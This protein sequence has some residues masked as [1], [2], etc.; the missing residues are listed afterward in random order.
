MS[1]SRPNSNENKSSDI[2]VVRQP[3]SN[4][5]NS[6]NLHTKFQIQCKLQKEARKKKCNSS[7]HLI[8]DVSDQQ[9]LRSN[10][11]KWETNFDT[12]LSAY[13]EYQNKETGETLNL[14]FTELMKGPIDDFIY[15]ID[16]LKENNTQK[17]IGIN[18]ATRLQG[19]YLNR[20]GIAYMYRDTIEAI[21]WFKE[22]VLAGNLLT[23]NNLYAT[24]GLYLNHT[25]NPSHTLVDETCEFIL[26]PHFRS[27]AEALKS[28]ER[29]NILLTLI[30]L[31]LQLKNEQRAEQFALQ[32]EEF[33]DIEHY[34]LLIEHLNTEKKQS[35]HWHMKLFE[36]AR[37]KWSDKTL[38][39]DEAKE[40]N[41]SFFQYLQSLAEQ[42]KMLEYIVAVEKNKLLLNAT[43]LL[44]AG[45]CFVSYFPFDQTNQKQRVLAWFLPAAM[46]NNNRAISIFLNISSKWMTT[47]EAKA[48]GYDIIIEKALA[49]NK[50]DAELYFVLGLVY[51]TG[52]LIQQSDSKAFEYYKKSADLGNV[53]AM[54]NI[55]TMHTDGQ[56]VEANL[57]LATQWYVKSI[58][59]GSY[60]AIR[61]L[62]SAY[63]PFFVRSALPDKMLEMLI[64]LIDESENNLKKAKIRKDAQDLFLARHNI[65]R[66]AI[67]ISTYSPNPDK[68]KIQA[69]IIQALETAIKLG[70]EDAIINASF[71]LASFYLHRINTS[72]NLLKAEALLL[73]A[74][75]LSTKKKFNTYYNGMICALLMHIYKFQEVHENDSA[76][77]NEL[78]LQALYYHFLA[79][80]DDTDQAVDH[81]FLKVYRELVNKLSGDSQNE[82]TTPILFNQHDNDLDH[83][84]EQLS[85]YNHFNK[86]LVELK[87]HD[88]TPCEIIENLTRDI[89]RLYQSM[90]KN[91]HFI[92]LAIRVAQEVS[93]YA[94]MPT[95]Q[96]NEL[97]NIIYNVSQWRLSAALDKLAGFVIYMKPEAYPIKQLIAALYTVATAGFTAEV[98]VLM[99]AKIFQ[100][101]QGYLNG[102]HQNKGDLS[103][104][105]AAISFYSLALLDVVVDYEPLPEL[106][107]KLF[108]RIN[109]DN[110]KLN[111][112]DVSSIY[113]AYFYF[114]QKYPN[115][116][117]AMG[118]DLQLLSQN[119]DRVMAKDVSAYGTNTQTKIFN[120]LKILN[121]ATRHEA[122]IPE[123]GRRVDFLIGKTVIQYNGA[124]SH[125][126]YDENNLP[127]RPSPKD[128]LC[129]KTLEMAGY[130]VI[131]ISSTEWSDVANDPKEALHFLKGKIPQIKQGTVSQ[132][133][134][135]SGEMSS[136]TIAHQPCERPLP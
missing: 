56:G 14:R 9:Q 115:Y 121:P 90:Y 107:Q 3:S 28:K 7:S 77:K 101:L 58:R 30:S 1:Q 15:A 114:K 97:I 64:L 117:W 116:S 95:M 136:K 93:T 102:D 104:S 10:L 37:K 39:C 65:S 34:Y 113:H 42:Q 109:Q 2:I 38:G 78:Q 8:Q 103:A 51:D 57:A 13:K 86:A 100:P 127:S 54:Q 119:Y 40:I 125:Y 106:A 122:F 123:T 134:L 36:M 22:S 94:S 35:G 130:Q 19:V 135:W 45:L 132:S 16:T 48:A 69:I 124:R 60:D 24:F 50:P 83:K 129:N 29:F 52:R 70:D 11:K 43:E 82:E 20:I 91:T 4:K 76:K 53:Q 105:N 131:T 18:E 118:H 96:E 84:S 120:Q 108:Q 47:E 62:V 99:V 92:S 75:D 25:N 88:Y 31:Q 112:E 17:Y 72:D 74:L 27:T 59:A 49:V 71:N 73:K 67:Y 33:M 81:I 26:S 87:N 41:Q 55:A 68:N 5:P 89:T 61:G 80:Q 6:I 32:Y 23:L 128:L 133:G 110:I 111:A 126:L 46:Q 63:Q 85:L 79:S 12:A 44:Q 66:A 21:K 98:T